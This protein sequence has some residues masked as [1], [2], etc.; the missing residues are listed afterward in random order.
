[1]GLESDGTISNFVEKPAGDGN[2]V[3]GGF[4]I[5]ENKFLDLIPD[6]P[7]IMLEQEP[8]QALVDMGQL[9]AYRHPSFW[10][11]MDTLREKNE[12]QQLWQSGHAPWK[13]WS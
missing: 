7:D 3:N 13:I 2:L 11:P 10:K 9:N 1:M 12:L 4:F 8:L 5:F 6:G